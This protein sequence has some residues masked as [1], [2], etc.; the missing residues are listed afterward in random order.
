MDVIDVDQHYMRAA[1]WVMNVLTYLQTNPILDSSFAV[2]FRHPGES[3]DVGMGL[4]AEAHRHWNDLNRRTVVLRSLI[5]EL[6]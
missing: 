2:R 3:P 4:R 1:G 5:E 6:R